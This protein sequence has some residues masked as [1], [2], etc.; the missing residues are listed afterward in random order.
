MGPANQTC[1]GFFIAYR[2]NFIV[3]VLLSNTYERA[4]DNKCLRMTT[5]AA[6]FQKFILRTNSRPLNESWLLFIINALHSFFFN[7]KNWHQNDFWWWRN[8]KANM[9]Q[10]V[11]RSNR[12]FRIHT[13][14]VKFSKA[15]LLN[16]CVLLICRASKENTTVVIIENQIHMYKLIPYNQSI[17]SS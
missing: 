7:R 6:Y 14:A 13:I 5:T 9:L 1:R 2:W 15:L 3:Y 4:S 11:Y 16:F 12:L 10:K 17:L 8:I